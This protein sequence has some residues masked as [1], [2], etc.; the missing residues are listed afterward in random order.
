MCIRDR[1]AAVYSTVGQ[2]TLRLPRDEDSPGHALQTM[3]PCPFM[4]Q[5][6]EEQPAQ[7]PTLNAPSGTACVLAL[8]QESQSGSQWK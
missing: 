3:E 6:V 5:G 8:L 7:P 4:V 2:V 1:V